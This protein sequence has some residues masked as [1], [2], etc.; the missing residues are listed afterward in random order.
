MEKINK[1]SYKANETSSYSNNN[2]QNIVNKTSLNENNLNKNSELKETIFK[3]SSILKPDFKK[4]K[5]LKKQNFIKEVIEIL[6][7]NKKEYKD[8][9][10]PPN[11]DSLYGKDNTCLETS[12]EEELKHLNSSKYW[13]EADKITSL[14]HYDGKINISVNGFTPSDIC[15]GSLGDCYFLSALSSVAKFPYLI[16][17]LFFILNIELIES[18]IKNNN[19]PDF[20]NNDELAKYIIDFS[21]E[22]KDLCMENIIQINEFYHKNYNK[23]KM[24]FIKLRIHGEW[25][26][27]CLD[28]YFPVTDGELLFAKSASNDL[29]VSI[30]EKAWAK[31]FGAYYKTSL[32]SPAE[33]FLSLSDF[34]CICLSHKDFDIESELWNKFPE[35]NKSYILN[36]I[37]QLKGSQAGYYK[38]IGL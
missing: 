3:V 7:L 2:N 32:G 36:C 26:Y 16:R 13:L 4:V 15:Q 33:G 35:V 9:F 31:A 25:T 1:Q 27:M 29:W 5:F 20:N 22:D 24:L 28:S 18:D 17:N 12:I 14:T 19:I 11:S 6:K 8:Q 37:I 38:S 34:P 30:I 10:F 23:L 21:S